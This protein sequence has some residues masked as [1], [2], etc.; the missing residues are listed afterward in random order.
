MFLM[1]DSPTVREL[2][3]PHMSEQLDLTAPFRTST[4]SALPL[5]LP[6]MYSMCWARLV[7]DFLKTMSPGLHFAATFPTPKD[8]TLVLFEQ[9]CRRPLRMLTHETK[10]PLDSLSS[11]S[12]PEF[13]FSSSVILRQLREK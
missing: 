5:R 4:Y 6:E 10:H 3:N 9:N 1:R 13:I 2:T 11:R 8:T 12:Q 7:F